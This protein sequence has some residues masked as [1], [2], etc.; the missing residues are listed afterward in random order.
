MLLLN[1][2]YQHL[3]NPAEGGFLL[4]Q[5]LRDKGIPIKIQLA[6]QLSNMLCISTDTDAVMAFLFQL[7]MMDL[8]LIFHFL[9]ILLHGGTADLKL[10]CHTIHGNIAFLQCQIR[11]HV[12]DAVLH[13]KHRFMLER[14]HKLIQQTVIDYFKQI[15]VPPAHVQLIPV[16]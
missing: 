8:Q 4:F 15:S 3:M 2:V 9:Q 10:L 6:H 13:V 1:A 11:H 16:S 7:Q 12:L 14:F 5:L